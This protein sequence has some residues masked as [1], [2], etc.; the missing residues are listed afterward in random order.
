[1]SGHPCACEA[2]AADWPVRSRRTKAD[3][4]TPLSYRR[5]ILICKQMTRKEVM[6]GLQA[7]TLLVRRGCGALYE[8]VVGDD[9]GEAAG[10]A[11]GVVGLQRAGAIL[12]LYAHVHECCVCVHIALHAAARH[13][14]EQLR[15]PLQVLR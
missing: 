8:G 10:L 14:A 5:W 6:H 4:T 15:R 9:V 12:A 1:M 2:A 11:H 3:D 13:L 7:R